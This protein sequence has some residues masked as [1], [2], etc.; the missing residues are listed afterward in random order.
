MLPFASSA[1]TVMTFVARLQR[2][3]GGRPAVVPV[4][5]PLPPRSLAQVT[6]DDRRRVSDAV[7][8]SVMNADVAVMAP[9]WSAS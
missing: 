4:V 9:R 1:D 6:D 3:V 8:A 5:V 2:D 7:P